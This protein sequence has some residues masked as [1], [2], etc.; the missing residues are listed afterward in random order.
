MEYKTHS[1]C[2]AW[3]PRA[4]AALASWLSAATCLFLKDH[5]KSLH[6][7][8]QNLLSNAKRSH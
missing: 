7:D 3:D 5:M 4:L 1:N 8:L 6:E 2:V